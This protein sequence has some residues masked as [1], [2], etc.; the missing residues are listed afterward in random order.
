MYM[1][2]GPLVV[3]GLGCHLTAQR[4]IIVNPCL[5]PCLTLLCSVMQY[6]LVDIR[7]HHDNNVAPPHKT[8]QQAPPPFG[9]RLSHVAR[10]AQRAVWERIRPELDTCFHHNAPSR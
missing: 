6:L 1:L 10:V 3:D 2:R 5:T 9:R 7:L 8:T 4:R